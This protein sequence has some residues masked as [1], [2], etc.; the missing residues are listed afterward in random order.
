MAP[1]REEFLVGAEPEMRF[2]M[3]GLSTIAEVGLRKHIGP[4]KFGSNHE[5]SLVVNRVPARRRN[6]TKTLDMLNM[7]VP[8]CRECEYAIYHSRGGK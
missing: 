4:M 8:T 1:T 7:R 2:T 5:S 3:V 6:Y